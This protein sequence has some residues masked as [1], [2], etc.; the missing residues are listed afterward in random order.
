MARWLI[1]VGMVAAGCG[2]NQPGTDAP[3]TSFEFH[4]TAGWYVGETPNVTA[5]T[6]GGT[7]VASGA[8]YEIDLVFA[9]YAEALAMFQPVPVLITTTTD[10]RTFMIAPGEC[11]YLVVP[12]CGGPTDQRP[13]SCTQ[14]VTRE[15]DSFFALPGFGSASVDFFADCGSCTYGHTYETAWCARTRAAR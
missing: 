2:D 10:Q 11:A 13:P 8:Q 1:A 6:I 14:P 12:Q 15:D 3:D 9:S 4:A 5:M 7:P